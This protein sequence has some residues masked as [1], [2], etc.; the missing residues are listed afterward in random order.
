MKY[1][2]LFRNANSL[3]NAYF[4]TYESWLNRGSFE[5]VPIQVSSKYLE[6]A[7]ISNGRVGLRSL[8]ARSTWPRGTKGRAP[9]IWKAVQI[10]E[11]TTRYSRTRSC[12][13]NFLHRHC[14]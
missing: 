3:I 9:I 11:M 2:V 13:V 6:K 10:S 5:E 14:L 8:P 4:M 7:S 1:Q 12:A